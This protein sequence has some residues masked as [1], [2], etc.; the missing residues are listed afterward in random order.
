MAGREITP[1]AV[2]V[3]VSAQFGLAFSMNYL[4]VFLPFYIRS[5]SSFPE[6][7]T[8]LWTG[9]IV[10]GSPAAASV[11]SALWGTLTSRVS[12]KLLFLRGLLTHTLLIAATAFTTSLPLLLGL[13]LVQ[14]VMGGI[15]TIALII[16]AAVSRKEH[17]PANIGL[18]N[19]AMTTGAI[20]GPPI[21]A[22][23][24]AAFGFR[25]GFLS[26]AAVVG[27]SLLLCLRFLPA[28]SPRPPAP[29]AAPVSRRALFAAWLVSVTTMV[30]LVFLAAVLPQVLAGFGI[31]G[32]QAVAAAGLV[33]M[34]YGGAATVGSVSLRWFGRI[35]HRRAVIAASLVATGLQASLALAP[36]LAVFV[37][38][39][40]LQTFLAGL[41]MPLIMA[42]VAATG[43]G[44]AVGTLNTARFAGNAAAP[45]IATTLLAR[46]NLE[47][48]YLAIAVASLAA[49]AVFVVSGPD[50]ISVPPGGPD[51][52]AQGREGSQLIH[53]L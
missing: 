14:G 5:V 52:R 17:L 7:Q 6:A 11:A 2:W 37:G 43:R 10:G 12:P 4:T 39:R 20:V 22:A 23:V 32:R 40:V 16:I 34:A 35:P 3:A 46:A 51:G 18:L 15:S 21:G 26:A 44:G 29:G 28:V 47:I 24:V 53:K 49:L 45:V 38:L 36:T 8:L 42:D 30:Q 48:A 13:R 41:L 9:L 50:R 33:V 1:R 27:I 19:S 31:T 25:A